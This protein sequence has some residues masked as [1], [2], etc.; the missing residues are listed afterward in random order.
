M[1]QKH[2]KLTMARKMLTKDEIKR[3]VSPFNSKA[4]NERRK[5]RANKVHNLEVKASWGKKNK[6]DTKTA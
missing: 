4:W 6:Y 3:K 1:N 2:P 5:L